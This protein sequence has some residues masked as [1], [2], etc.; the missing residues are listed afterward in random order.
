MGCHDPC[1]EGGPLD[2]NACAAQ[3]PFLGA[4]VDDVCSTD[5]VCC[6]TGWDDICVEEVDLSIVCAIYGVSC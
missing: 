2:P 1:V 3:N 6:T 5:D 4:C